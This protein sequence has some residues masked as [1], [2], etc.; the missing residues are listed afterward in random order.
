MLSSLLLKP[1]CCE[2]VG[3]KMEAVVPVLLLHCDCTIGESPRICTKVIVG[4][5]P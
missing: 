2:E 1:L 5:V 3:A 4:K